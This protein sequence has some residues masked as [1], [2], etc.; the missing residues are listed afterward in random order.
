[1]HKS[2]K[3]SAPA[4]AT[5]WLSIA[6][7]FATSRR[8]FFMPMQNWSDWRSLVKSRKMKKLQSRRRRR[9]SQVGMMPQIGQIGWLKMQTGRGGGTKNFLRRGR[10]RIGGLAHL[11]DFV[12]GR[13]MK[14]SPTPTG[15]TRQSVARRQ[16]MIKILGE[17]IAYAILGFS[18]A[19]GVFLAIALYGYLGI[20]FG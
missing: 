17:M 15:A 1:M 2:E 14:G 9:E 16:R 12:I 6:R 10:R 7:K 4:I 18:A 8:L 19:M 11:V 3:S 13:L 20:V 5:A